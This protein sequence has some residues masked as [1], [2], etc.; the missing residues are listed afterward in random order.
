MKI[1][2]ILIFLLIM[3]TNC[4]AFD[5]K[6]YKHWI[7]EDNDCQNTRQEV[8]IRDS[9]I[10]PKFNNDGCKVISGSWQDF[11]SGKIYKN[12]S[13]L[14]IDHVV[15]LAEANKAGAKNWDADYKTLYANDLDLLVI[16]SK[17]NNRSKGAKTVDQW[18]PKDRNYRCQYIIK[19]RDIKKKYKLSF[20][21]KEVLTI[22][23]TLVECYDE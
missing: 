20:S 11:Y 2:K 19:Y 3:S 23:R 22:K 21:Q 4:L 12:P 15:A 6:D 8:L 1:I 18:L 14:D 13:D 10:K 17:S 7:D 5:R 16:S 9:I